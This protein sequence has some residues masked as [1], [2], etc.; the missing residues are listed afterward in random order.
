MPVVAGLD[1]QVSAAHPPDSLGRSLAGNPLQVVQ[2]CVY[3]NGQLVS[4][5]ADQT[6][7]VGAN[8]LG[9]YADAEGL[10]ENPGQPD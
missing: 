7:V 6:A 3:Q 5:L 8:G 4:D 2:R 10:G 1:A 9:V